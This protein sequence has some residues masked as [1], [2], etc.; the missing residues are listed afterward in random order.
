MEPRDF[1]IMDKVT[2]DIAWCPG[3]G[4]Y[5]I[6]QA[7]KRALAELELRPQNI[8]IVSGIGQAAKMPHYVRVNFY[9]GLHGRSLPAATAIKAVNPRTRRS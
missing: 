3:C 6:Q 5:A 4:N 1:D 9:N 8:V 2:Y 7:L